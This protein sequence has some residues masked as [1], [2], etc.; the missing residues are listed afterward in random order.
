MSMSFSTLTL[1]LIIK[2]SKRM[3]FSFIVCLPEVFNFAIVNVKTVNSA[4]YLVFCVVN[5]VNSG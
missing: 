3:S 1:V 4:E 5:K 2:E